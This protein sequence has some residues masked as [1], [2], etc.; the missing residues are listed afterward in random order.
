[1]SHPSPKE[2]PGVTQQQELEAQTQVMP[3]GFGVT[4]AEERGLM[5]NNWVARR[6]RAQG[7]SGTGV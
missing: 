5:R 1:L 4:R 3:Q 6:A 2:P 7:S